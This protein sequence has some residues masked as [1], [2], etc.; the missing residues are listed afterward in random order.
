[1][2]Q[3]ATKIPAPAQIMADAMLLPEPERAELVLELLRSLSPLDAE[4][5][6]THDDP[7][8]ALTAELRRRRQAYLDGQSGWVSLEALEAELDAL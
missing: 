3:A 6:V 8:I 7:D 5:P 4:E 2:A 1:M